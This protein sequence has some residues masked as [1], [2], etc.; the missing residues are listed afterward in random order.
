M[1]AAD[2][3]TSAASLLTACY[4][5]LGWDT[6][7]GGGPARSYVS[8]GPPAYECCP[9]L[10]VH[11][12]AYGR[13]LLPAT[14]GSPAAFSAAAKRTTRGSKNHVPFVV[15]VLECVP[16]FVES[17]KGKVTWPDPAEI[18]AASAVMM[19]DS[20]ILWN[21][22]QRLKREDI[23]FPDSP[24]RVMD[25]GPAQPVTDQGGCGGWTIIVTAQLDG[26]DV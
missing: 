14:P 6:R 1:P 13:D 12:S 16:T 2:L 9:Q 4:D 19:A 20:W 23:L 26:S 11:V 5:L 15:T 24:C 17:A 7:A 25:I 18:D 22:L 3:Y 8:N 21:G 10:T